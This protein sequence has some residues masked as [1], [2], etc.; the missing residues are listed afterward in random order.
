M[1]VGARI[2]GAVRDGRWTPD[3]RAEYYERFLTLCF[4]HP[5]VEAV[6]V[7]GLGAGDCLGLRAC[8][9][10]IGFERVDL[11]LHADHLGMTGTIKRGQ[12]RAFAERGG[13]IALLLLEQR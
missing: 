11:L 8:A 10:H 1:P 2:E 7:I 5:A 6:N 3:L 4:S 13:I 9:L 12:A